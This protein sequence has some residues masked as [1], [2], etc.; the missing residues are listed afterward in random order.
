[1]S[2]LDAAEAAFKL[3][4]DRSPGDLDVLARLAEVHFHMNP[5]RGRSIEESRPS[6]ERLVAEDPTN[7]EAW[8]HLARLAYARGERTALDTLARR[9]APRW[10]DGAHPF[11]LAAWGAPQRRAQPFVL[12]T[13]AA[14]PE[15]FIHDF[16][17]R[18]HAFAPDPLA[19]SVPLLE[20][21]ISAT[22][23][24]RT[25]AWAQLQLAQVRAAAGQWR[26]ASALLD[27]ASTEAPDEA[28]LV[29]RM[30]AL[31]PGSRVAMPTAPL[32]GDTV[33]RP[34]ALG[35]DATVTLFRPTPGWRVSAFA[36]ALDALR[37]GDAA[38]L[39]AAARLAPAGSYDARVLAMVAADAAQR[40]HADVPP[41]ARG[42]SPLLEAAA[43]W[44]SA[45]HLER[46]GD[47]AGAALRYGG[48]L[49][50]AP[51][52]AM[53]AAPGLLRRAELELRLGHPERAREALEMARRWRVQAEPGDSVE[54]VIVGLLERR[55]GR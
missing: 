20:R 15:F 9:A 33:T 11:M 55:G 7:A 29:R 42:T 14:L 17:E 18:V 38:A 22:S 36:E 45:R 21:V 8:E 52:Y 4:L 54:R 41:V 13:I 50:S 44:L 27:A 3:A 6:F 31:V 2:D 16:V 37:S 39:D 32:R 35:R 10:A 23:S 30:M 47:L 43:I 51:R 48:F 24:P 1:L 28:A 40:P 49:Y 26:A 34:F 46:S 19:E 25:R 53:Y 5:V 12:D